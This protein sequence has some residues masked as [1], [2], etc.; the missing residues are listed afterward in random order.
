MAVPS[1]TKSELRARA[2]ERRRD[3]ARA[4]TS[5]TRAALE[6]DLG[7]IVLPQLIGARIVAGYHPMRDEIS[8]YAVLDLLGGEQVAALPWFGGR[9]VRMMFRKAPAAEAGPW[10]VLQPPAT[11]EAVAP[12]TVLVPLVLGDRQGTRIGHGKGHYDRALSHLRAAGPVRTIG[13]AW[14][15][16]ISDAPLPADPWDVPLDAIA[17]P[18]EWI[19]CR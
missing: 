14:E 5:E 12:D 7:R 8:P 16:Q 19:Q 3:Y 18:R 13:I 17:T 6:A 10:G 15:T 2:L 4:L 11:A 1:P 9:D